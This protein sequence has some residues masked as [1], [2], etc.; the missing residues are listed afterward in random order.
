MQLIKTTALPLFL[1]DLSGIMLLGFLMLRQS[2]NFQNRLANEKLTV[3]E[4][5]MNQ[6]INVGNI[7]SLV[8]DTSGNIV[9]CNKYLLDITKYSEEEVIHKNWFDLFIPEDQ[10][11]ERKNTFD[12]RLTGELNDEGSENV[13]LTKYGDLIFILWHFTLLHGEKNEVTE[14]SKI[15]VDITE[16]RNHEKI[17]NEKN[18]EYQHI[19]EELNHKNIELIKAKEQAEESDRLKTAFLNNISHEIRTPFNGILGFLSLLQDHDL[20]DDEREEFISIINQ[21]ADRLMNTINDIIEVSHI[22]SGI[23][24]LE[25]RNTN[26]KQ[27]TDKLIDKFGAFAENK[28]LEFSINNDIPNNITSIS[29]DGT[30]LKTILTNLIGNA[31]KFTRNG[32]VELCLKKENDI[33]EFSVNDTGIGISENRQQIIFE[34][35]MQ[36]NVSKTREFE[37]LGLGLTIV[38]EYVKMLGGKLWMESEEGKGTTFNF[39]IPYIDNTD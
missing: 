12:K 14:Y 33:L 37:G 7:V 9:F 15:G 19:N 5:R 39:T 6:I 18:E 20:P 3:Y 23:V 32:S 2:S 27:L 21:S 1:F 36:S 16:R 35:F 24:K 10:R 30:K 31:L 22:Q 26:I 28:G 13:I 34:R 4:R 17:I 29:T 38:K 25:V 8:L 11:N